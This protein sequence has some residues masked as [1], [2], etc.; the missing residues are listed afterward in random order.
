MSRSTKAELDAVELVGA[1][2]V[3]APML[4]WKMLEAAILKKLQEAEKRGARRKAK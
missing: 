2:A 3:L 1:A 4:E